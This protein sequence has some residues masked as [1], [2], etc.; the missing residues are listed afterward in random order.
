MSSMPAATKTSASPTLAQHTP[1]APRSI[2]HRATI[3]D[4][5][6]FAWGRR[7]TPASLRVS[8]RDRC[9][10]EV[11]RD[12]RGL[13]GSPDLVDAWPYKICHEITKTR[14]ETFFGFVVSCC[15]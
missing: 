6:V 4:L 5:C 14:K 11:L 9:L 12:R 7:R 15:S 10:P 2:C 8:E 13:E 3:G 1:T